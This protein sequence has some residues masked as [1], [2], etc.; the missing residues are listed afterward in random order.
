MTGPLG[1]LPR[2]S[3]S[4]RAA[5]GIGAVLAVGNAAAAVA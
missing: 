4:A 5:L 2:L 1:A 3:R